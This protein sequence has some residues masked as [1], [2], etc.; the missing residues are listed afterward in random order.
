MQRRLLRRFF[1][2]LM[3]GL[4]CFGTL[5]AFFAVAAEEVPVRYCYTNSSI[6]FRSSPTLASSS[7][8]HFGFAKHQVLPVLQ[9]VQGDYTAGTSLW[10]KVRYT[11]MNEGK[12]YVGYVHSSNVT[13]CKAFDFDTDA[14]SNFPKSYRP[15]LAAIQ[16]AHPTWTFVPLDTKKDFSAAVA[17]QVVVRGV[18]D[19]LTS[20]SFISKNY[21]SVYRSNA[22]VNG[23]DASRTLLD[24]GKMYCAN[25]QTVAYYMDPRNF[26]NEIDVFMFSAQTFDEEVHTLSRVEKIV[27]G[28]YMEDLV[29]VNS[30]GVSVSYAQ[31]FLDAGR[32][33]GVSPIYLL[34]TSFAENGTTGTKLSKGNLDGGLCESLS[35]KGNADHRG[36][37]NFFGI[38][39]TPDDSVDET[40]AHNGLLYAIGKGW[41]TAYKAI[42]GGA[43]FQS[44]A[45]ISN[46]QGTAY[47]KK[48]NVNPAAGNQNTWHQYMQNIQHPETEA[49][50][51]FR[52]RLETGLM[53]L[54]QEFLIPVYDNLPDAPAPLPTVDSYVPETP[55][56]SGGEGGASYSTSLQVKGSYLYGIEPSTSEAALRAAF[57]LGEGTELTVSNASVGTGTQVRILYGGQAVYTYYI[58][59][60]GDVTGDGVVAVKDLLYLRD[61]LRDNLDFDS[62]CELAADIDAN[63]EVNLKD[64][65]FLRDATRDI[66]TITQKG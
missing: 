4:V 59:V 39:S 40:P 12:S 58:I 30:A 22:V 7:K 44:Q 8:Y 42:V 36:Y 5:G 15:Y 23:L 66:Y 57:T 35:C 34:I 27:E 33:T 18:G 25:A 56:P 63:G 10:Y 37:Y 9:E 60:R 65:L 20:E 46:G 49:L 41:D 47:L 21:A 64:L 43:S 17:A 54:S 52:S 28:T 55:P 61:Y 3:A 62:S 50:L 31:A 16:E 1:C 24:G 19:T 11:N 53:E 38:G 14:F 6:N 45:Y 48:F 32:Q 2:V 13:V 26:L 51:T 29:T